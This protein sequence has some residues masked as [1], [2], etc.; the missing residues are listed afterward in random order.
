MRTI[1]PKK[2]TTELYHVTPS[3]N[4]E[5]ILEQGLIPQIGER[6][7]LIED[8]D[9]VYLFPTYEDCEYALMNWLGDEF[10]DEFELTTLK[11]TLPQGFPLESEVE[12]E[13]VSRTRIPP[14]YITFYK[15][16]E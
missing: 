8:R 9:G 2:R 6:S 1:E 7:G 16:E 3:R 12:W 13:R 15:N 11:V 10:E 14:E 5:A 4:V